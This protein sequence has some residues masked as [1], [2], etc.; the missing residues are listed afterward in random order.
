[1]ICKSSIATIYTP[2]PPLTR[3]AV[4]ATNLVNFNCPP[5]SSK[6]TSCCSLRAEDTAAPVAMVALVDTL[7]DTVAV[8]ASKCS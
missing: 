7:A 2:P 8:R 6:N 3:G 4:R 5:P 1:M